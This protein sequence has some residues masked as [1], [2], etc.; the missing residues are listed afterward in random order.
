MSKN[1]RRAL[2]ALRNTHDLL[3]VPEAWEDLTVSF[4]LL[5]FLEGK[6]KAQKKVFEIFVKHTKSS[7]L[8]SQVPLNREA[9]IANIQ[10]ILIAEG[11]KG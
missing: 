2:K 1:R 8:A 10:S 3:H 4:A 7:V 9:M 11:F 5:C 6:R